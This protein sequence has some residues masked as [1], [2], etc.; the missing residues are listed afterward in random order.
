MPRSIKHRLILSFLALVAVVAITSYASHRQNVSAMRQ[1]LE[2]SLRSYAR[3]ARLVLQ[4]AMDHYARSE[5]ISEEE[6]LRRAV[7]VLLGPS[8]DGAR[9]ISRGAILLGKSGYPFVID[10]GERKAL[11]HPFLEGARD[12]RP[13]EAR[14]RDVIEEMCALREGT[15]EYSWR[16]PNEVE[17]RDKLAYLVPLRLGGKDLV[18]GIS[19]YLDDY[20]E[21]FR[22][23]TVKNLRIWIF[24]L[25]SL[26][27]FFA[28]IYLDL[29]GKISA[30]VRLIR[31]T[32]LEEGVVGRVPKEL[33]GEDELSEAARAISEIASKLVGA[34]EEIEA[35]AGETTAMN[36]QLMSQQEELTSLYEAL[37]Q[38]TSTLTSMVEAVSA[39]T[40]GMDPKGTAFSVME[41]LMERFGAYGAM[42]GI[43]RE[44][45]I[46][47]LFLGGYESPLY[48]KPPSVS[49]SGGPRS[50]IG[51]AVLTRSVQLWD[52]GRFDNWYLL[53]DPKV[54][55]EI[56]VPLIHL[57]R[58]VGV[59]AMSFDRP[60]S[61]VKVSVQALELTAPLLGSILASAEYA[62]KTERLYKLLVE[63]LLDLSE[64]RDYETTSHMR[65]TE[66]YAR[67]LCSA[68]GVRGD[69]LEEIA[70][71]APLHDIGKLRVPPD[72]VRKNGPLTP[73]EFEEMKRHVLYGAEI[74]GE[75][76]ELRVARN[77]CLYHHENFDG[78]G[79][80][81]GLRG[82]EIPLEARIVK[83]IDVYDALREERPYKRAFSHEEALEIITRGDARV[84]PEHFDPAVLRAFLEVESVFE[85][86][87]EEHRD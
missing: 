13:F 48:E 17:P 45:R 72:I 33:S 75:A 61:E 77:I 46:E 69:L 63:K 5:G 73:S 18:V 40:G 49:L 65:R 28:L 81:G 54:Q 37:S 41:G 26:G 58:V 32:R 43:V 64:L 25:A 30:L 21:L 52:L 3:T 85:Q 10:C 35:Y 51:K 16:N 78:S 71:Y 79:Y 87:F 44:D 53:Y 6:A 2:E 39:V 57:G 11:G 76:P 27:L 80:L 9:D 68:L 55:S 74:I 29:T 86:I 83:L 24:V 12:L 23:A 70:L 4:M 1:I 36:E 8:A 82:E 34:Y 22:A 19:L 50:L 47:V 38:R 15:I 14:G 84:R 59:M 7:D 20:V 60:W 42:M 66:L 31:E 67:K 62:E 56:A